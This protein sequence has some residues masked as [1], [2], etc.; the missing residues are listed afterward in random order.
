M[1]TGSMAEV[2]EDE[3]LEEGKEAEDFMSL[4]NPA[5]GVGN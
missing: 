3:V 1:E 5:I 2:R 4:T